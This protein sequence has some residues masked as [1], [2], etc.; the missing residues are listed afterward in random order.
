MRRGVVLLESLGVFWDP[1]FFRLGYR[2]HDTAV[3][4]EEEG[5]QIN[6]CRH[7]S[8]VNV[9]LLKCLSPLSHD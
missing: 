2:M 8:H 5:S 6:A 7:L 4:G 9:C 1:D 3:R